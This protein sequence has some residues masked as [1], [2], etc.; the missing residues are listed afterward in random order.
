MDTALLMCAD[1]DDDASHIDDAKSFRS[2][3]SLK[4]K[5][6]IRS[7]INVINRGN[8]A[9]YDEEDGNE[10]HRTIGAVAHPKGMI[11]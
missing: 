7:E 3:R 8:V 9:E 2:I 6:S 4:S 10:R 11:K 5:G 1:I